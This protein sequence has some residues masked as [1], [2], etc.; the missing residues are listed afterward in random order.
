[1]EHS[2]TGGVQAFPIGGRMVKERER[3]RGMTDEERAWRKQYLKDQILTKNE[4][5]HV[6]EY[7]K[8][9]TNPIRRFYQFPL[10]TVE[11]IL[12]PVIVSSWFILF[13]SGD[14][15]TKH[16]L[17]VFRASIG[18]STFVSGVAKLQ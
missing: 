12:A 3:L 4:P 13:L 2:P 14:D 15:V 10:N 6:P 9:R 5:V 17:A 8:Q 1:M 18:P 7:W 16:F 11:K